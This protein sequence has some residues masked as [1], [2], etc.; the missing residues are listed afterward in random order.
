MYETLINSTVTVI[1]C[2][3]AKSLILKVLYDLKSCGFK[4]IIVVDDCCPDD[5]TK[6]IIL[7]EFTDIEL[8]IVRTKINMGVGGAF[9]FGVKAAEKFWASASYDFICKIDADHQHRASD[10]ACMIKDLHDYDCDFVK[11]NR[12]MLDRVPKGQSFIRKFGNIGLTF[13]NKVATGYWHISDPINGQFVFR[14]SI[15]KYIISS[16][17]VEDRYLF[18]SSLLICCS[19][20]NAKLMDVPNVIKYGDE[21]SSLSIGH[22]V[23]R[24]AKYYSK[25]I[26]NRVIREYFYPNFDVASVAVINVLLFLPFAIASSAYSLTVSSISGLPTEPGTLTIIM[27]SFLVALLSLFFFVS[28]DTKKIDG[29]TPKYRY[30]DS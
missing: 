28:H 24:F 11:G 7:Q 21:T 1:P 17:R 20:I 3:R 10:L 16:M 22:E 5:S 26:W 14:R 19:K 4:K 12:Y 25:N 29:I 9:K 23:F 6:N 13:L 27:M 30:L 8:H 15:V 18:E 2:F